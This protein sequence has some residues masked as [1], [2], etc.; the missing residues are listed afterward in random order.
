MGTTLTGTTPQDT[1]D[2]LIKVTDNGPLSG[3]AKFLS[4]GLGNDS[5][6]ALS[7]TAVGVSETSPLGKLHIKTADTSVSSVSAQGNL[8]VLEDSENGLSILSSAA[9]AGYILFGDSADNDVAGIIYDHS[10]NAMKFN[11]NAAE[12]LR[13]TS[14]GNVGIG[15]TAP[16][17]PLHVN[18]S[19]QVGFVDAANDAMV[20][21]WGG[22]STNGTIQTF[23]SSVLA[24]NPA[25]N[26]VGI[27]TS[28]P[29]EKT[30]INGLVAVNGAS[31]T[32]Y[33]VGNNSSAFVDFATNQTRIGA[34]VSSG[35]SSI[36]FLTAS[37]GYTTIAERVRVTADG[38]TFNGDTAAANALDD[39]EEGTWTMGVTFG[40]NAVG[41]TT[42]YNTG[43]Y[44]KIGRQ[45]T[46]NGLLALS[47]K[48]SSTGDAR[49]TGLPFTIPN[50]VGNYAA[51]SLM[52]FNISFANQF[53]AYG[54]IN[55]STIALY[56]ITE[57]G[58]ATSLTDAD[59]VNNSEIIISFTYQV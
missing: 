43:T 37:A 27:G 8:L 13:I 9:G 31:A 19:L 35:A 2:S 14:A 22:A 6:L 29:I 46:V 21:T 50:S 20:F 45:V 12:R 47:S 10:A 38:L 55:S 11:T 15:L 42:V 16:K 54:A 28:S 32:S 24:L 44:T 49:I 17:N 34:Q 40:G 7:T 30:T 39:Y 36:A 51:P 56:E 3:T 53:Q 4:D 52:Y 26:N 41:V 58:A 1:Y 25:G 33:Y 18:T 59:F 57:A 23:S 48:G 5:V